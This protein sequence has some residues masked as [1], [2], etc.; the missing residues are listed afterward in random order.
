MKRCSLCK[1]SK[2]LSEFTR[3]KS[4]KTGLDYSCKICKKRTAVEYRKNHP[5]RLGAYNKKWVLSNPDKRKNSQLMAAYGLSLFEYRRMYD[6]QEGRCQI[7]L[8]HA[9]TLVRGLVVDHAHINNKIRGLLCDNCNKA[10]GLIRDL[11]LI[12]R[13]MA[14]Y[15]EKAG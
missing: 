1:I 15:L 3:D 5:D 4:T 12:A 11:P 9:D 13:N 14:E 2:P 6:V 8:I 7:C 10:L